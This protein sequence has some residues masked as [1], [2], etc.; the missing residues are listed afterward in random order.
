MNIYDI[1]KMS[2][3]SI[4]TV[5]R[6]LNNKPGVSENARNKVMAVVEQT[7]FVPNQLAKSLAN[8]KSFV[9]GIVMPG[10][11]DY[12]SNRVDAI[13]KVCKEEG[14]SLMI[15]SNYK[16]T[17]SI[18]EDLFNFNLLIE[19]RVDGIIYFPTHVSNPH[20]E[21]LKKL[22][23]KIPMV[24]TDSDI[25]GI[26]IS[27]VV[28]DSE[29]PT[30]ELMAYLL[31]GGHER[32]GYINGLS[33]DQVNNKRYGAY[34][35]SLKNRGIEVDEDLVELGNFSFSSG[36][37]ALIRMKDKLNEKGKDMPTAIFA[38]NDK[39]AIGAIKASKELGI[40]VPEDLSVVSYDGIE[41][42]E[43]FIPKLTTVKVNQYKL[44]QL[45]AQT[46]IEKIETKKTK[47][48]KVVMDHKIV[49]GNSSRPLNQEG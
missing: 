33:Y 16:D 48:V 5:S 35:S 2:G 37:Q 39:M 24:I 32:I 15:T 25:E 11:N 21:L 41:Y 31:D 38:A 7:E 20:Y 45:A 6:V 13:H 8:S 40:R 22:E 36:Y 12:Y 30:K 42:S 47:R 9:I 19:K 23:K 29:T 43:F 18:E 44:G 4:A 17:N 14:Y 49:I 27:C 1:A 28:Q 3:V 10:I 34:V 26:D 46:L